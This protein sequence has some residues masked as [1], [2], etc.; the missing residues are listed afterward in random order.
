[1]GATLVDGDFLRQAMQVDGDLQESS[2]ASLS[3]RCIRLHQSP[4][5][6]SNTSGQTQGQRTPECD[7]HCT[8]HHTRTA[9]MRR[10]LAQER[11]EHQ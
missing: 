10:R 9:D 7:A 4:V 2:F 6:R 1:V 5:R 8:H 11:E 3:T